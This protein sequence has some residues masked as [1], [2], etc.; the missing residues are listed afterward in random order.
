MTSVQQD[1]ILVEDQTAVGVKTGKS[2]VAL[3]GLALTGSLAVSLS[4]V[5]ASFVSPALRRVCL[6][7]VPAT[8]KQIGNVLKLCK[9]YE[10]KRTTLVDLGS[11]D[12]RIVFAAAR[13]GYQATGYELNPWLVIY[14]KV[15]AKLY[16]L[17][18]RAYFKRQDL[19]KAD[20]KKFDNIVIFGVADMMND[21]SKKIEGDMSSKTRIIACRFEV[22]RWRPVEEIKDGIDSAWL[23]TKES[24][25]S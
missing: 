14:S 21:L 20:F 3:F 22:E 17:T 6:P 19:W 10:G 24:F 25:K 23:Y 2:K 12:G 11:G 9:K 1:S 15:Y 13:N 18:D 7:Y 5:A 4:V 16:G 8:H